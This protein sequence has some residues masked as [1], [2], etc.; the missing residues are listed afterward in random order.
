MDG[1]TIPWL[2]SMGSQRVGHDWVTS[3]THSLKY[4]WIEGS[5]F[6]TLESLT[7][8]KNEHFRVLVSRDGVSLP[9]LYLWHME[10]LLSPRFPLYGVQAGREGLN[11]WRGGKTQKGHLSSLV[12]PGVASRVCVWGL[13]PGAWGWMLL[14]P[15]WLAPLCS[16]FMPIARAALTGP[17]ANGCIDQSTRAVSTS[18]NLCSCPT[19]LFSSVSLSAE[20]L[21]A[22]SLTPGGGSRYLLWLSSCFQRWVHWT[23]GPLM[24]HRG[25]TW[26]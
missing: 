26:G 18:F 4:G 2:Q 19:Q 7:K 25:F 5:F 3:L 20:M 9:K 16:T 22:G 10:G 15:L 12:S 17:W 23:L 8:N 6:L 24:E 11:C 1:G 13:G 21:P 14:G